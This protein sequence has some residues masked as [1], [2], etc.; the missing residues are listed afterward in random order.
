ML[1]II[2]SVKPFPADM[3]ILRIQTNV[4]RDLVPADFLADATDAFQAAIGKPKQAG[5]MHS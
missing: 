2:R 3:P 1:L 4:P 5:C